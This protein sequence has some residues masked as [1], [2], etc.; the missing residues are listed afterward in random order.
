[1]KGANMITAGDNYFMAGVL[2]GL[3]IAYVYHAIVET[4]YK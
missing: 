2:I 4:T 1:M 3:L